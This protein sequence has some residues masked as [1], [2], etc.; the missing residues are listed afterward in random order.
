MGSD[1]IRLL[2]SG[3]ANSM[4]S[5]SWA[6]PFFRNPSQE[7]PGGA[8]GGIY[9]VPYFQCP[10]SNKA[11]RVTLRMQVV[12]ETSLSRCADPFLPAGVGLWDSLKNCD[13]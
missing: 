6:D 11:S 13:R 4:V 7:V 3:S 2:V 1:C 8:L 5:E 10:D 12:T 9:R